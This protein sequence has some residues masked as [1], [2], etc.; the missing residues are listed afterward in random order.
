MYPVDRRLVGTQG[1]SERCEKE[2]NIPSAQIRKLDFHSVVRLN[3]DSA[4]L[5]SSDGIRKLTIKS[6]ITQLGLLSRR[7]V[8]YSE[9]FEVT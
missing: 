7:I 5:I 4:V 2:K 8:S 3:T 6:R 9:R 1:R